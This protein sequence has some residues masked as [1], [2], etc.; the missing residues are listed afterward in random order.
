MSEINWNEIAFKKAEAFGDY[1]SGRK[2]KV[3]KDNLIVV[4][5]N[6]QEKGNIVKIYYLEK[7]SDSENSIV[8]HDVLS[9]ERFG[10]IINDN[11]EE[12]IFKR[13]IRM[14][15]EKSSQNIVNE[16]SIS[17]VFGGLHDF[18]RGKFRS[19]SA[20]KYPEVC[21]AFGKVLDSKEDSVELGQLKELAN[22]IFSTNS[23]CLE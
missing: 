12:E 4:S 21:E 16:D 20:N 23:S 11:E 22:E 1:I 17:F 19:G 3:R 15:E 2:L 13:N 10:T 14:Y 6:E 18:Y 5:M 7:I 8:V 9:S